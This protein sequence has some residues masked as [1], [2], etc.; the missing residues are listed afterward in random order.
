[1]FRECAIQRKDVVQFILA[2]GNTSGIFIVDHKT[3]RISRSI[4]ARVFFNEL[5]DDV[6]YILHR[7]GI[8]ESQF[9]HP[10]FAQPKHP[11]AV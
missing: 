1:M 11:R 2:A 9:I 6:L 3:D 8:C 4:A 7:F 10:V 5:G